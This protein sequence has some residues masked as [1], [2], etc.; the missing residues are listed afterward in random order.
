MF[1]D[2]LTNIPEPLA[3]Y[4]GEEKIHEDN[5]KVMKAVEANRAT[6][7]PD[8]RVRQLRTAFKKLHRTLR[9]A[10]A[11][12]LL[13][14]YQTA[15][16]QL[17][18]KRDNAD[19]V[20][21]LREKLAP[22]RKSIVQRNKIE[23]QLKAHYTAIAE[24]KKEQQLTEKMADEANL[25][26]KELSITLS[27][28]GFKE[29]ITKGNRSITRRVQFEQ[30]IATA[31]QLQF[32]IAADR[33]GFAGGPT[34]PLP[35]GVHLV[36]VLQPEVMKE[37]SIRMRREVWSPQIEENITYAAGAWI[38]VER[39]GMFEG[40]PK[41]VSYEQLMAR[42]ETAKHE[43][44]PIPA[45][46][47]RGRLINWVNLDSHSST[48]MMWTGITGSGKT[49]AIQSAIS[50]VIEKHSPE[51]I[52]FIIVDLKD[53]GDFRELATAPHVQKFNETG[54]INDVEVAAHV[55]EMVRAE[56]HYRQKRIGAIAKN[57]GEYN[58]R[59]QKQDRLPRIVVMFDEYANTRRARFKEQAKQIDDVAIE[60]TQIGRASGIHLWLGIQQPRPDNMPKALKDNFT[61]VFV[62][63]QANIG[64]GISITGDR[65]ASRLEDFPGR[66]MFYRG[67]HNE[68]VQMPLIK[69]DD[70]KRALKIAHDAYGDI[71]PYQLQS[72]NKDGGLPQIKTD[73]DIIIET[74]MEHFD[75]ALKAR[76]IWNDYLKGQYSSRTVSDIVKDI[77]AAECAD[78][79]G[80]L[81]AVEKQPGNFYK[82][83]EVESQPDTQSE[84]PVNTPL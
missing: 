41:N 49:N 56:M 37:L 30:V 21:Q 19:E 40:I 69:D 82:L 55:L 36:N 6:I 23:S 28:M 67:W 16:Q 1:S 61:T 53:Q 52:Q 24:E 33:I 44:I 3:K 68:K 64:A 59:V 35:D 77:I 39:L 26:G 74:A 57:L 2:N 31:D 62:G 54:V 45:G 79:D 81:Y 22:L 60:I 47:K 50:A 42:Y 10:K 5:L 15:I 73:A 4:Y 7:L 20:K 11:D 71:E 34:E 38:I 25:V 84:S 8:E 83:I 78:Y 70:I 65:S 75:G 66:M 80:K 32:R 17:N 58:R 48:H 18:S 46:V 29:K 14:R 12:E 72:P 51:T 63:H 9:K 13:Q 27:R 76:P 43:R